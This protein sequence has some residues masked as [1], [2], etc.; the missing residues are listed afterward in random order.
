M[1]CLTKTGDHDCM[2]EGVCIFGSL[3]DVD[4]FV[5]FLACFHRKLEHRFHDIL[6]RTI[7]TLSHIASHARMALSGV[8]ILGGSALSEVIW[9]Y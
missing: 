7:N 6:R 9:S 8:N 2:F 3:S 4:I 5:S 1:F